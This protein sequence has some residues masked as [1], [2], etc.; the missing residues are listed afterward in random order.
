MADGMSFA[1]IN[2]AACRYALAGQGA[3]TLVLIHE[4]GGSLNSWDAMLPLL[5]P[6][7]R[8]LRYDLRG[9]GMSE[10]ARGTNS[11]DALADDLAALLDHVGAD[12]P[13][14]VMAAAMGAAV[15]VRFAS[16]HARRLARMVLIGPALGVPPERREAARQLTDRIDRDGMRAIA[17]AVLP[18]AFPDELWTSPEARSLAIARWLGADPEGYAANYRILVDHD[19]RPELASVACPV[20]VLAGRFD[21]FSGPEAVD[22]GT[23]ALP[24]RLFR[25]VEGGHFM[26]VQSPHLVADAVRD[27]LEAR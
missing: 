17:D 19:L 4:L 26:T 8:V 2:G 11:L 27:F 7:L 12:G 24:D 9:A 3:G 10:K 5:P 6:T 20:L 13:V 15:A 14:V 16:R 18:K 21:P 1:E 25:A 22:A 23:A